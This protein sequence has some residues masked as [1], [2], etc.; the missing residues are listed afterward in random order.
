[1]GDRRRLADSLTTSVAWTAVVLVLGSFAWLVAEV[2]GR[3]LPRLSLELLTAAPRDAG[4]AGGIAP[5]LASTAWLAGLCLVVAL[6]IGLG[7]GVYL[8]DA[9]DTARAGA[10]RRTLDVL[11]S[12]PSIVL[13]LFGAAF[14]SVALGLGFSL[15]SGALTLAVMVLPLLGRGSEEALRA[16]PVATTTS[17]VALGL[18]RATILLRVRLPL[19]AAGIGAA[20]LLA[21]AR[22]LAET[23]ALV[24]TSGYVDR[25]PD[26]PLD[27]GRALSVHILDLAMNVPG[28]DTSAY[29]AAAVLLVVVLVFDIAA[30]GVHRRWSRISE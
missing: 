25:W 8:A 3:G 19:A 15:L 27:P 18:S 28:G 20:T 9:R 29:A 17:A 4:R 2:F 16:V 6:P 23:A 21:L 30:R 24:F 13:G 12:M 11:A 22:A 14:F 10:L 7:A 26:G 5:M 1:M